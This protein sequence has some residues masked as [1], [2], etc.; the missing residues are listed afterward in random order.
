MSGPNLKG[1]LMKYQ[2]NQWAG[3]GQ[4]LDVPAANYRETKDVPAASLEGACRCARTTYGQTKDV[5]AANLKDRIR[6][7]QKQTWW[8]AKNEPGTNL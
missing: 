2:S 4:V 8:E 3:F 6:M 1:K 5:P 7:C